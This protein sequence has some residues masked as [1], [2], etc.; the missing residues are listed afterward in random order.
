MKYLKV[1]VDF[2]EELEPLSDAECG[3]LFKA[4]LG[5]AST[6]AVPALSGNERFLWAGAKKSIDRQDTAYQNKVQGAEQAR[7]KKAL[8]DVDINSNQADIKKN[9]LI[10]SQDKDKD[11][12]KEEEKRE[13]GDAFHPPTLEE[14][15]AY[16]KERHN[17]VNPKRFLAWYNANGWVQGSGGNPVKDWKALIETW[18]DDVSC[19]DGEPK[20]SKYAN[21]PVS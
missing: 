19:Q 4:M 12:D 2:A 7:S 17:K 16:C 14:V 1:F 18:E 13:R 3:R 10:S 21:V 6:G 15:K 11:K 9:L 5:Y 8:I 20:K